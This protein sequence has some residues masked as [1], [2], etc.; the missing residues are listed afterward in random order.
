MIGPLSLRFALL[1]LLQS[2]QVSQVA[3]SGRDG[4][5]RVP[6]PRLEGSPT[7]DGTLDEPEWA[8]AARLVGFSQ[9]AP[10]DGRPAEDSTE[11]LVWYSSVAIFFGVRA[12]EPHGA[13]HATLADRDRIAADDYVQILL[14]TFNDHRQAIVFGVNPLGVQSDGVL[15]EGLQ[16]NVSGFGGG[17][18][19]R[20][21]AD[22]S[23]DFV[24]QSKG[25]LTSYGYE[26]EI[27][28]PFKSLRYQPGRSQNW[29][30]NVIRQVQHSGYQNTWTPTRRAAASFLGQSGVL[31]GLTDLHRGLVLDLNPEA[32]GKAD[33]APGAVGWHYTASGPD[34]G[35]NVRWGIT[36]NLT[37]TGTGNPDFS[38]VEADAG[39]LQFDPRSALF[40]PEKRPFFLE[41]LEQFETP[42]T[43]VYTRRLV[44][45]IAAFKLSGKV[46]GTNVGALVGVDNASASA[47]GTDHPVYKIVRLRRDLVGQSTVGLVYTDKIDGDHYNRVA[48]ADARLVFGPIYALVVQGAESFTR[49]GGGVTRAPLWKAGLERSGHSFALT[50]GITGIHPDF[51][52]ASGFIARPGIVTAVFD[53]QL[54]FFGHPGA[55]VERWTPD[56]FF[57]G[58]WQYHD[59]TS[60][61]PAQ[62]R[63]VHVNLT[64]VLRG[65]WTVATGVFVESF[66]YD[67]ALYADYALEHTVGGVTDTVPFVGTPH[68]NNLDLTFSVTTPQFKRFSGDVLILPAIQ[69]EN[70]FEW[71][72]ARI[73]IVQ[74]S[75]AWR[76]TDQ[77]RVS[78]TYDHQQYWRKTDGSTVGVRRIPRLK[79]EYQLSR[80][81]FIRLVGQYDSQRQ[82]SLR[83]DSRTNDPIL[84]RDPT[85]GVYTRATARTDN[86]VRVD[87]LLS[88]HPTP[89]TV[90]YAGYGNSMTEPD[91]LAFRDLRRTSDGFFVKLSYLFR[92]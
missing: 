14:D 6:V 32:T 20:D 16:S 31:T 47:S 59:F 81:V 13:V 7:I 67:S 40:F 64:G 22:L 18:A 53:H 10:V 86:A 80:P 48:G 44:Q 89:G 15:N 38:Q 5:V 79:V 23:A 3:Y 82:D 91:A 66:G 60:G 87:W 2:G 55:L 43:L 92:M 73:L 83:D 12:F 11:V 52:A 65:G 63:Q 74:A 85:T 70:F 62:D 17:G 41:G 42:S 8:G 50:Y 71:A 21:T 58:R 1:G 29:G 9:Y 77:L 49:T 34:V 36:N 25:R 78:A 75:A 4:Q 46:S 30:L 35:G 45:P 28:I 27:R 56:L 61:G 39:Q 37:L 24:Y 88:Y 68:I 90:I 84:I 72:P 26:V 69:D 33:G 54:T 76:P 51:T 19:V 57:L